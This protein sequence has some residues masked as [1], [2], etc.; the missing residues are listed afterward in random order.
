MRRVVVTGL[1]V[2]SPLG[3]GTELAWSR[4]LAGRSGVR[5]MPRWPGWPT[6]ARLPIVAGAVLGPDVDPQGGFDPDAAASARDRRKMD[7]FVQFALVAADEAIRAAGVL[8]RGQTDPARIATVVGSSL[9]GLESIANAVRPGE[10]QEPSRLSPFALPTFLGSM[11][12]SWISIRHGFK[13][14][15]GAPQGAFA[16]GLQALG[17][18]ARLIRADEADVAI[19]GAS[20]ACL[21]PL[22]FGA[23]GAA[24]A[25][26]TGCELHPEAV[27]RPFD[28]K[29][30]GFVLAE[31][32]AMLVLEALDHAMARGAQPLAELVGYGTSADAHHITAAP[33]DGEGAQRAMRLALAQARVTPAVVGYLNAHA[34]S[35]PMGDAC[36]LRAIHAVF[37]DARV[38]VGAT[39]SST[40]HLLGAAGAL[41][42]AFTVLAL[43]DQH[44]PPTLNLVE[45]D[46]AAAGIDLLR[47]ARPVEGLTHAMTNSFGFGGV[48]AS[49]IFRSIGTD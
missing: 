38:A 40:G 6:S 39:K 18:G 32:A 35:T 45:P 49:A 37:G 14:P 5:S 27:S 34:T 28:A 43:R 7:R 30:A 1:G 33:A 9:G 2:V 16:A 20:E 4:L 36:E 23:F 11:G 21:H 41:E 15:I 46:A 13:G 44:L 47:A 19:C 31:G 10:D 42:A 8:D 17:D 22:V 48:N 12:A 24:R 3:C 26:A 29:R 25:L